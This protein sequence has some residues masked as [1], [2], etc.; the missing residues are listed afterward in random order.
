MY[1]PS[2]VL[3]GGGGGRFTQYPKRLILFFL[4]I[5]ED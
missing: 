3:K 2:E 4:K 5:L 1:L